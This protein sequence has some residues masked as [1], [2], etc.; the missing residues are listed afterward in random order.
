MMPRPERAL[1][2]V[3]VAGGGITGLWAAIAFARAMPAVRV[4]LL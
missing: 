2:T 4:V 1:R 3:L